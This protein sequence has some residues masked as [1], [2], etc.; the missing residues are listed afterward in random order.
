VGR[1]AP[2]ILL[3]LAAALIWAPAPLAAQGVTGGAVHGRVLDLDSL[4]VEQAIVLVVNA[5]NGERWRTTTSARGRYFIEYLSVGGPYRIE[6]RAI[7]YEPARRDSIFLTLGQRLTADFVL[8]SAVAQLQEITVTGTGDARFSSARTGPA[9]FISDSTIARLPVRQRDYTELALLSPQVTRSPNG[10][11]SFVGQHDRLNSIQ[12]DGTNNNDPFG[13]SG[14]GNGTPG[15]A[16]GLRAFT[17]EAVKELQIIAAPFDVRYGNFAGG[18]INAVTESGSNQVEGSILGYLES[19]DFVGTDATGSRGGEFSRME[20]GLTLGAPIV[21]DRVALF[22]NAALRDEVLPQAV[23]APRSDTTGGADS[24]GVGIRYESLARFRDVLLGYGVDPGTFTA[25]ALRSPSRNLFTKVTA[26]LGVNSHLGVSHNYG[27]GNARDETGDRDYGFYFLSSSGSENPETINATRLTWTAA[28]GARFANELILARVDDRRTCLPNSRFP[29]VQVAVDGGSVT[30]GTR[31]SCLGLETGH[32]TWELTDNLGMAAGNHRLTFGVHGELIDLVDDALR[33]PAGTW[34]F[35][36]LGALE[37]RAPSGYFRTIA[38]AGSQVAFRAN[39]IAVYAQ[40]QWV[41]TPRLTLTA[42]LRLD[43][44]FVPTSPLQDTSALKLGVNTSLTPSG[45]VLWS[46][47]VGVNYD[48]SGKGTT[49]LRGGLGLFAGRPAYQWFRNVY[50]RN[51]VQLIDCAEDEVPAFTLDPANPPA[52]CDGTSPPLPR[53]NYFDP[54]FRFPRSL[55]LAVGADLLLPGGVVGTVDL[56]YTHGVNTFDV[57]DVNLAEP[58]AV[59]TG[60]G[61]RVMYGTVEATG[62]AAPV[63]RTEELDALF[64]IRNGGHTQAFSATGQLQKRFA[65]GTELSAAYTYTRAKDRLSAD[66]DEPGPNVASTPVNG[67]LDQRE[68]RTSLWERPHKVTLVA[69]ADLPL[70]FQLGLVYVGQSSEPF[71][72]VVQGDANADGFWGPFDPSD[73]VVYVPKDAGDITLIDQSTF[74]ALDNLIGEVPCLRARRGRLLER[75]TCRD[76][77][78][79]ETQ[80]R[81]AKRFRLADRRV[82]EVTADLFNVLSFLDG[83][84]GRVRRTQPLADGSVVPLLQLA[85]Y[86]G[87]N[88]RGVYEP[89]S[90]YRRETDAY[91]SR[92]RLQLGATLSF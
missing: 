20:L 8:R 35:D 52:G 70:G 7:G 15:W 73:D 16:V 25:G 32:T 83:D 49:V 58:S 69:T 31:E 59:A 21:R 53:L 12:I 24:A 40:D 11:L 1:T 17:P 5:S 87:T 60:E 39:Q 90:V 44:P 80:A 64:E 51:G 67:T 86:D 61:G 18:L 3:A 92:W 71:T 27:H 68:L 42:G 22:V 10:G 78:V 14:S 2:A 75:N 36:S 34:L 62:D 88:G 57:A 81:L 37:Q 74:A 29:G 6:V 89:L 84:W 85:G 77:W 72:Y 91:A 65:N 41:P 28:F 63:R 56:L 66:H 30:A 50:A 54:E 19:S 48:L 9:Q 23:P 13:K 46:P 38:R 4:P 55:K 76:P 47:R 26:Q 82:L 45:N 43:V 79:H 33:S